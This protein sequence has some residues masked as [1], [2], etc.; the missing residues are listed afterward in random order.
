MEE[1]GKDRSSF[2]HPE[3][4][5]KS[6]SFYFSLSRFFLEEKIPRTKVPQEYNGQK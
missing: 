2:C 3:V 5:E 6:L 1:K 4:T